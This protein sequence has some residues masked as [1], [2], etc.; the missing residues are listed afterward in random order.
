MKQANPA[1]EDMFEKA[2][3]AFFGPSSLKP[4]ASVVKFHKVRN[5]PKAKAPLATQ[6]ELVLIPVL[7]KG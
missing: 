3:E 4:S 6:E 1:G 7:L 5:E 2:R